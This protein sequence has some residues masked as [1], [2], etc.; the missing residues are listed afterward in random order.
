MFPPETTKEDVLALLQYLL[1]ATE[2]QDQL[3]A[4]CNKVGIDAVDACERLHESVEAFGLVQS[5]DTYAAMKRDAICLAWECQLHACAVLA[6]GTCINKR[7]IAWEREHY[8]IIKK[9][10][11]SG[12]TPLH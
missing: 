6:L 4:I 1:T 12:K 9:E 5:D 2:K 10:S 7:L 3:A 11:E 8:T